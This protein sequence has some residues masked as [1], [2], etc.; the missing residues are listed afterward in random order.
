MPM[1]MTAKTPSSA[2]CKRD[3]GQTCNTNANGATGNSSCTSGICDTSGGGAGVCE[4]AGC[5]NN[6]LEAGDVQEGLNAAMAIGDDRLQRQAQ[7][8]VVPE[9]FTHGSSEQRMRWFKRGL[10]SG[11]PRDCDTFSARAL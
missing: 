1:A 7:G 5:G 3:N 6:L 10:D 11:R 4:A 8:R 2:T 9:S